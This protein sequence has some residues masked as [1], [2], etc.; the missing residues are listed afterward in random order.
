MTKKIKLNVLGL[1]PDEIALAEQLI[2]ETSADMQKRAFAT[3]KTIEIPFVGVRTR[4]T[5]D[6]VLDAETVLPLFRNPNNTAI[7]RGAP[8]RWAKLPEFAGIAIPSEQTDKKEA[9]RL[10]ALVNGLG[11]TYRTY[12]YP[13]EVTSADFVRYA[14]LGDYGSLSN[15]THP[16]ATFAGRTVPQ[17]DLFQLHR[18]LV[19]AAWHK[20][21]PIPTYVMDEYPDLERVEFRYGFYRFGNTFNALAEG[22][23]N[24]YV[25]HMCSYYTPIELTEQENEF[26]WTIPDSGC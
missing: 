9:T 11:F 15:R 10:L 5:L 1:T 20:R 16:I 23:Y 26:T 22:E 4:I 17:G 7:L 12:L 8:R 6:S 13:Y 14:R 18:L 19:Q 24:N 3:V 2:G 21:E 25:T